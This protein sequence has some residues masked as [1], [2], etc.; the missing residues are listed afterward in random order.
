M[1][2][3]WVEAKR[4]LPWLA[5]KQCFLTLNLFG[6]SISFFHRKRQQDLVNSHGNFQVSVEIHQN[7]MTREKSASF[8]E[9]EIWRNL[10]EGQ[11]SYPQTN[12]IHGQ[13]V[14]GE[15]KFLEL[16]A[17]GMSEDILAQAS[18]LNFVSLRRYDDLK[19]PLIREFQRWF[20]RNSPLSFYG[21]FWD[22]MLL[23]GDLQKIYKSHNNDGDIFWKPAKIPTFWCILC[24]G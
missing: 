11:I 12:P 5:L 20:W 10:S 18:C 19:M 13:T 21:E 4:K 8:P 16:W 23:W 22:F 9:F 15:E 6:V 3:N 1:H 14:I 2:H 24:G 17:S 7:D